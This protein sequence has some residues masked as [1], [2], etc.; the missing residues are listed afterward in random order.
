MCDEKV[1]R[2]VFAAFDTDK[3]GTIDAKELTAVTKAYFQFVGEP[4]DDKRVTDVATVS[5]SRIIF[6]ILPPR[7]CG[8]VMHSV[9]SVYSVRA[10]VR[11]FNENVHFW[12]ASVE[13]LG[14]FVHQGHRVKVK[15]IGSEA[16]TFPYICRFKRCMRKR[17]SS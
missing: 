16:R 4:A 9:V 13:Y 8:V 3:S 15:V 10:L 12:Y 14:N 17:M 1:L 5:S 2:Q 7:Q 6:M 11:A